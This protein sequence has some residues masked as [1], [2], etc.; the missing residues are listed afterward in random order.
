MNT[1]TTQARNFRPKLGKIALAIALAS[2]M[3]GLGMTPAFGDEHDNRGGNARDR[4]YDTARD[5]HRDRNRHDNRRDNYRPYRYAQP[6]Y[7]P[8]PVYY[9]PEPSPGISLF[10]PIDLR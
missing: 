7:V 9:A 8:P 6:V 3:G 10:F 2:A 4:G 5:Q 1:S